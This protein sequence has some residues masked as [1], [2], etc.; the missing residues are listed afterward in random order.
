MRPLI[1]PQQIALARV[2]AGRST[3]GGPIITAQEP[4]AKFLRA[5]VDPSRGQTLPMP[6]EMRT[7]AAGTIDLRRPTDE[8]MILIKAATRVITI[9]DVAQLAA[10]S[11][12]G[13]VTTPTQSAAVQ[14]TFQQ[15]GWIVGIMFDAQN[16]GTQTARSGLA[17]KI[18]TVPNGQ[19]WMT[20]GKAP[21]FCML[22]LM[23]SINGSGLDICPFN[24]H[25]APNDRV[26]F[27]FQ[28]WDAGNAHKPTAAIIFVRDEDVPEGVYPDP[29]GTDLPGITRIYTVPNQADPATPL[30]VSSQGQQGLVPWGDS[31]VVTVFRAD[32]WNN[33]GFGK[34]SIAALIDVWG[35]DRSSITSDGKSAA[36][37]QVPLLCSGPDQ[38]LRLR[39]RVQILDQVAV[40]LSNTNTTT[41]FA[42]A[43]AFM[44]RSDTDCA[45]PRLSGP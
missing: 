19:S 17:A 28:N 22:P 1:T 45:S 15:S 11:T 14:V 37:V 42:P 25:V 41:T 29:V 38:A 5:P 12:G 31:G 35:G 32:V 4:A 26:N 33:S 8:E 23:C 40:T 24:R 10:A 20:D 21:T 27:E 43:A 13:G 34:A 7:A 2:Q 16:E 9:P 44:F 36:F 3:R 30:A 18:T 39:K 6:Q